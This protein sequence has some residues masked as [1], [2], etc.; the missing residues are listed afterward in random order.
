FDKWAI[1]QDK[2]PPFWSGLKFFN[3]YGPG[4]Y[5]KGRM[6]SVI[7]HAYRQIKEKGTITLFKSHKTTYADGDQKR[8]FIYVKD[9]AQICYW[10]MYNQ[11][12]SGIY[13]AGTGIAR[14]FNH[15]AASVFAAL[16]LPTRINYIDTPIDIRAGYQYYTQA[17][18]RKLKNAGYTQSF[19]TLEEA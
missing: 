14:S 6:A 18:M 17:D 4:E 9:I 2:T 10:L 13:N 16:D 12:Q 8:D 5:H 7:Y 1:Q 11:P 19:Y 15:L 3:V